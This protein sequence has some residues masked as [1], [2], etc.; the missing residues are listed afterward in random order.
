MLLQECSVWPI[1]FN[2][3]K[4]DEFPNRT[5]GFLLRL[6][7][8]RFKCLIGIAILKSSDVL[9]GPSAFICMA[10]LYPTELYNH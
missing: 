5:T 4:E 10:R 8:K 6:V 9:T 7:V 2:T 3:T 1:K